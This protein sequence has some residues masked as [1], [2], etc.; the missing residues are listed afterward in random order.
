MGYSQTHID[1]AST[2]ALSLSLCDS[3]SVLCRRSVA[4]IFRIHVISNPDVRTPVVT[5]GTTTFFHIRTENMYICA[6]SK[7]NVNTALVRVCLRA[8]PCLCL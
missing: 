1:R 8:C 7:L 6:V 5:F 4:E 2:D 3:L